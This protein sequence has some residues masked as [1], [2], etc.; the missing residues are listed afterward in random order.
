MQRQQPLHIGEPG[1]GKTALVYGLAKL[2]N[3]NQVPKR[4]KGARIYSM[5]IAQMLA[6]A[7]YRGDFRETYQDGDG[8]GFKRKAT[9]SSISMRN[10]YDY[11]RRSWL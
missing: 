9:P 1:V 10:T 4:L 2:I 7:Q 8:R 3:E 11:G 5:D 6:G